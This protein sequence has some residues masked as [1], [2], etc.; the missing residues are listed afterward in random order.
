MSPRWGICSQRHSWN[1]IR[2]SPVATPPSA[3]DGCASV[4]ANGVQPSSPRHERDRAISLLSALSE[5]FRGDV[6]VQLSLARELENAGLTRASRDEYREVLRLALNSEA[7]VLG[8]CRMLT[9]MGETT[10]ALATLERAAI[11]DTFTRDA[12]PLGM[13]YS[14]MGVAYMDRGDL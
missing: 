3:P 1:E 10:E 11:S 8:L 4:K 7:G 5:T 13:L 9:L 14:I 12:E 6:G 2:W